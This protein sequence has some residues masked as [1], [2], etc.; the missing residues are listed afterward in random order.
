MKGEQPKEIT[1]EDCSGKYRRI[2]T[3]PEQSEP[4]FIMIRSFYKGTNEWIEN[5]D[6]PI[7]IECSDIVKIHEAWGEKKEVTEKEVD[8]LRFGISTVAWD[9]MKPKIISLLSRLGITVKPEESG[10]EG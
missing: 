2:A 8:D 5:K 6:S 7:Y 10:G 9:E 1:L 3:K 4:E